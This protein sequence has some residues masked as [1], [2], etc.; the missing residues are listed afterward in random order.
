MT[1][2]LLLGFLFGIRHA[3]DADH[4]AAVAALATSSRSTRETLRTGLSWGL[5]HA[6]TLFLVCAAVLLSDVAFKENLALLAEFLVGVMLVGLGADVLRRAARDRKHVHVHRHGG[7]AVHMHLHSHAGEGAH[8][9]SAHHHRHDH[10]AGLA[11]R[12]LV[13]GLM[14]GLAGS[15]ALVV[16]AAAEM[17]DLWSGLVYVG[18]FGLGS[19]IGMGVLSLTIA[20]PLRSAQRIAAWGFSGVN[21]AVGIGTAA[22]GAAVMFET[23]PALAAWLGHG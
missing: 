17:V 11:P 21:L 10:A 2:T 7:Q 23:G 20:L 14:H 4:I 19:V 12:A 3:L 6:L 1:Y 16:F 9:R 18:L 13:V 15:A 5:G 8:T 22:L